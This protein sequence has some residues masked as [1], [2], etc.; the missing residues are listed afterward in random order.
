MAEGIVKIDDLLAQ[1]SHDEFWALRGKAID[2]YSKVEGGLCMLM[3]SF[4]GM[5]IG[6]ATIIFFKINNARTVGTVLT[7]LLKRKHKQTYRTFWKSLAARVQN[8][9]R[10][11][12]DIVHNHVAVQSNAKGYAGIGLLPT[13]FLH[14]GS[15][16]E[17]VVIN[18]DALVN[19]INEC[20]FISRLCN[21]FFMFLHP[22]MVSHWPPEQ[23]QTW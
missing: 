9:T 5:D 8:L 12:N 19:F 22:D 17:V 14:T 7:K 10:I 13:D 4:G 21:M 16:N 18:S 6:V 2:A 20:N 1:A 15:P 3:S 23:L 11:R